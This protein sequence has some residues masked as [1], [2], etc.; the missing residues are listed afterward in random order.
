LGVVGRRTLIFLPF[1]ATAAS[2]HSLA[3]GEIKIGHAWALPGIVGQ[4]GQAFMPL[5][6][7][8]K[9]ADAIVA[10]RS[11]VCSFIEFRYHAKYDIL[12]PRQMDLLPGKPIAMRPQAVHL[13]LGGL[14]KDLKLDDRFLLILDFLNQGE[15]EIEVYV[16][17]APG[18]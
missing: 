18:D 11:D 3:A 10:A 6:N 7:T 1:L 8:G 15:V 13:R 17:N 2:A 14:N 4:D 12:A 16:E 5:L 9:E